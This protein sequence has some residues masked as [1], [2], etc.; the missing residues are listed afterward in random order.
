MKTLQS[1]FA[2]YL[3]AV[4]TSP[5]PPSVLLAIRKAFFAGTLTA[6]KSMMDAKTADER[7]AICNEAKTVCEEEIKT[8]IERKIVPMVEPY[9]P[10]PCGKKNA[11]GF[12]M[13]YKFCC[14]EWAT[15]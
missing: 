4:H 6:I 15:Q 9:E 8:V 2:D 1:S 12:P 11:D 14:G 5:P 7:M 10:C 13:K 3:S